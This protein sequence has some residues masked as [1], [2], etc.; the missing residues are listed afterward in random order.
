MSIS[1][2]PFT[3][4]EPNLGEDKEF[5]LVIKQYKR[6]WAEAGWVGDGVQDTPKHGMFTFEKTAETG[7]SLS[8]Y[9]PLLP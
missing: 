9:S 8:P 5:A 3:D 1:L 4:G 6:L 2:S 7:R